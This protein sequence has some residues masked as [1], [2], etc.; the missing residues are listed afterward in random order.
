MH[1][2]L[3]RYTKLYMLMW[4]FLCLHQASEFFWTDI[5]AH[6]RLF[7]SFFPHRPHIWKALSCRV[8]RWG[9]KICCS[10]AFI[11]LPLIIHTIRLSPHTNRLFM[12]FMNRSN[13]CIDSA[14]VF[15]LKTFW[16]TAWQI[17]CSNL[18]K[19]VHLWD[20]GKNTQSGS[21]SVFTYF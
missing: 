21:S 18:C 19:S 5:Q 4:L 8:S 17:G 7:W 1:I 10:H 6:R 14:L 12:L 11:L 3:L 9:A 15:K 2:N 16:L 20:R 13:I